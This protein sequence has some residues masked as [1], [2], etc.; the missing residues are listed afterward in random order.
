MRKRLCV[1]A[2]I[3]ALLCCTVFT[4]SVSAGD[5][6]DSGTCG[7]NVT[8]T[9]TNGGRLYISG[10]GE[11]EDYTSGSQVPWNK[12]RS[13]IQDVVIIDG[14]TGI[15]SMALA[16]CTNVTSITIPESVTSIG[17]DAFYWCENLIAVYV[18][19]NNASYSADANGVLFNKTQ[20]HIRNI[21]AKQNIC[22][23]GRGVGRNGNQYNQKN[24]ERY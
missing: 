8:W 11:M 9:L 6:F 13:F 1:V 19:E 10:T 23:N 5:V 20:N 14:V 22:K 16:N 15:D 3:I 12:Y 2:A 24:N 18:D 4:V 7:E 17:Q 21:S